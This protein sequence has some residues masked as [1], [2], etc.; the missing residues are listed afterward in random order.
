MQQVFIKNG[1]LIATLG[2]IS[3]IAALCCVFLRLNLISSIVL[4]FLV[5][6]AYLTTKSKNILRPFIYAVIISTTVGLLFDYIG[7]LNHTWYTIQSIFPWRIFNLIPFENPLWSFLYFYTILIT[8]EYFWAEKVKYMKRGITATL[9]FIVFVFT[10]YSLVHVYNPYLIANIPYVYLIFGT[11][12]FI[13]PTFTY[14][15]FNR[16]DLNKFLLVA[17]YIIPLG[18]INEITSVALRYWEYPSKDFIGW[19]SLLKVEF[20]V[21]E[22][23]F[24]IILSP[25]AMLSYYK[26]LNKL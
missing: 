15:L 24:F 10:A 25:F 23:I 8:Y 3:I 17:A 2:F 1:K 20:P 13:I 19:V 11:V 4:F 9:I 7:A 5:P 22:L 12:F 6:S 16:K 14:L 26:F 21:E 18:F